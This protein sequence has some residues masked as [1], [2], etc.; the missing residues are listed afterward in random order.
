MRKFFIVVSILMFFSG[1]VKSQKEN[2][3]YK[4]YGHVR[5]DLFYNSRV[6]HENV[7]G[8]FYLYPKDKALDEDGKDINAGV[9]GSMSSIYTRLGMNIEGPKI[10]NAVSSANIEFDFRG[11]GSNYAMPRIRHASVNLDWGKSDLTLGQSWH[12]LFGEVSTQVLNHSSGVP[13]QPLNRSPLVKYKYLNK[14]WQFM[15]AAIWQL[16]HLSTG[17]NGSSEEYLKNSNLPELYA[18]INYKGLGW[19]VGAGVDFISIVPRTQTTTGRRIC[20]VCERVNSVSFE[21]HAKYQSE[22]LYVAAKSILASNQVHSLTLGGYA[23]KSIDNVTQKMEYTPFR[24]SSTW[25]NVVYGKKW[26]PG[27]FVGYFKNLGTADE[28]KGATYGTGLDVDQILSAHCQLTYNLPHWR[29]GFEYTPSVVWYGTPDNKGR[30]KD[31]HSITGH[32]ILAMVMYTF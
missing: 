1:V 9:N 3:S 5:G 13:F 19:Q 14:G 23:V 12:P 26:K 30:V 15:A 25:I 2:F 20:K 4:F 29:L 8:L 27:I 18:G 7:Y 22:N 16:Q 28:I 6:N 31:T 24:N 10:M 21:A 32:R 17:P 11:A